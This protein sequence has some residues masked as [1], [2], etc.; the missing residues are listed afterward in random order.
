MIDTVCP[1][2]LIPIIIWSSPPLYY[3]RADYYLSTNL[4]W[5]SMIFSINFC[6]FVELNDVASRLCGQIG[7]WR[8]PLV[9]CA[10]KEFQ[11]V[12][13]LLLLPQYEATRCVQLCLLP[14]Y[15]V[16]TRQWCRHCCL[17]VDCQRRIVPCANLGNWGHSWAIHIWSDRC[18]NTWLKLRCSNFEIYE[19]ER[20]GLAQWC[21]PS[22]RGIWSSRLVATKTHRTRR[23]L[24]RWGEPSLSNFDQIGAEDRADGRKINWEQTEQMEGESKWWLT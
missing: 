14:L 24:T 13:R 18:K 7:K 10:T 19:G 12:F 4:V 1:A 9:I 2:L 8:V 16:N 5:V 3:T 15:Y 23:G 11:F 22:I 21:F 17:G 6:I 20:R